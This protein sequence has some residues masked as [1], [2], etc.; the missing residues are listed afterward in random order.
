[1]QCYKAC[2]LNSTVVPL[3]LVTRINVNEGDGIGNR[4][5]ANFFDWQ[6]RNLKGQLLIR[7]AYERVLPPVRLEPRPDS[8]PPFEFLYDLDTP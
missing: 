1:M 4:W 6:L 7:T 3:H 2:L 5:K 8:I